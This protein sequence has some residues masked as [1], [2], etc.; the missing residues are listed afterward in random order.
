VP[1]YLFFPKMFIFKGK[2]KHLCVAYFAKQQ[3]GRKV[4]NFSRYVQIFYYFFAFFVQVADFSL[5]KKTFCT[6]G[7]T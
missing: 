1:D 3:N 4:T 6:K 7:S 2:Q 5:Q